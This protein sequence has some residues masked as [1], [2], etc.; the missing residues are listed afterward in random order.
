MFI[1]MNTPI[2]M[3]MKTLETLSFYFLV[4]SRASATGASRTSA[5]GAISNPEP[6]EGS[7]GTPGTSRISATGQIRS[8]RLSKGTHKNEK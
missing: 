1:T 2:T 6:F 5:T 3:K 8:L 4:A 7:K